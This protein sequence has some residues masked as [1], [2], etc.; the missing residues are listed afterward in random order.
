MLGEESPV[1]LVAVNHSRK[2]LAAS[3]VLNLTF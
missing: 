3:V 2:R 1:T